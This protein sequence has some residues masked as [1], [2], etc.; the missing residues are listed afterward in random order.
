MRSKNENFSLAVPLDQIGL[1]P[2]FRTFA[3]H[4][5]GKAQKC[6]LSQMPIRIV[7]LNIR[8]FLRSYDR[9]HLI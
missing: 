9:N 1:S 2:N 3:F 5:A 7:V 8:R 6:W 4:A